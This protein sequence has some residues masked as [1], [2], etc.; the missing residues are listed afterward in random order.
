MQIFRKLV[1]KAGQGEEVNKLDVD[2]L[3]T[4]LITSRDRLEF[5]EVF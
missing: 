3:K 1:I 5:A 4:F 2:H